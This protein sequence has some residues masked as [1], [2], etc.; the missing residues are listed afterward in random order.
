M[1]FQV[2]ADAVREQLARMLSAAT[3]RRKPRVSAFLEHAVR[4]TLDGNEIRLKEYSIGVSVFARPEDFDPR[5][6][7]IVRVEARRLRQTIDSYYRTEGADDP[8]FIQFRR[9]SYVPAFIPRPAVD[10]GQIGKLAAAGGSGLLLGVFA[11][12]DPRS[13][14][15]GTAAVA[16]GTMHI[17]SL[18]LDEQHTELL[19]RP[20]SRLFV[21]RAATD[22]D[23]A[24]LLD[25]HAVS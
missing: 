11:A 10:A 24:T 19:S 9:G 21:L 22:D 7:S 12:S 20:E 5:M 16:Q 1:R 2:S 23:L 14:A 25:G 18:P 17:M 13:A 4:E 8:M 3:F 6:D 15:A